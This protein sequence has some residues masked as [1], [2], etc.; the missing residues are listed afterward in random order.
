MARGEAAKLFELVEKR[1]MRLHSLEN[2]TP[3][4]PNLTGALERNDDLSAFSSDFQVGVVG[5]AAAAA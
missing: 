5:G 3:H 2:S 4:A 1:A